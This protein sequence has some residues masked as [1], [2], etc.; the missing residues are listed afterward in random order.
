MFASSVQASKEYEW[1]ME[2]IE[3]IRVALPE[4]PRY[5]SIYNGLL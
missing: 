4:D 5:Y 3:S 1:S 2:E